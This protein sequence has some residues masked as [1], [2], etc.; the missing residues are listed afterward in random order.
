[1][2]KIVIGI[3]GNT[4]KTPTKIYGEIDRFYVNR[5]YVRAIERAGGIPSIIPCI[6]NT[7]I[8]EA[9]ASL[10]DGFLF[11]GGE[12]IDPKQYGEEPYV[13]LGPIK[14]E[15][16]T[17]QLELFKA[18]QKLNKPILGICRGLQVINIG[19]GGT[20]FQDIESQCKDVYQHVQTGGRSHS[21]H[22]ICLSEDS[23]LKN[24]FHTDNLSV[25]SLHHQSVKELGKELKICAVSKD[26]ITEA[27]ESN[28]GKKIIG[29]QWHPEDMIDSA[30]EM[31]KLFDWLIKESGFNAS[32][33]E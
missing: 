5:S 6:G 19:L 9:Q 10:Y 3:V 24:I 2:K 21:I 4:L 13:Q 30:L 7:K 22:K 8:I 14:P 31:N 23:V 29:V 18:V 1:M 20:L 27:I 11:T 16:D 17:F 26:G 28:M 25:N 15:L 12:D 33:I 32:I